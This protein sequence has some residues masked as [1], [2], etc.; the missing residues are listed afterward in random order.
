MSQSQ[1]KFGLTNSY[2]YEFASGLNLLV[3]LSQEKHKI[4][5]TN[6]TLENNGG[7]MHGNFYM[8]VTTLYIYIPQ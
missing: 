2:S 8:A 4:N 1:I 6:L 5:L 3:H 7:V